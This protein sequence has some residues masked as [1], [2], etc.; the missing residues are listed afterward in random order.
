MNCAETGR[1]LNAYS[2]GEL[3]LPLALGLEEHLESC[4][5]CRRSFAS[6]QAVRT[7]VARGIETRAAPE[8]LRESLQAELAGARRASGWRRPLRSPLAVAAPGLIALLLA[9]W[10]ALAQLLPDSAPPQTR[11]VY[12]IS[13][14]DTASAALRNLG[15][16][17]QAAPEAKIVVVAHNN[18]VD[19]LLRGARDESGRAYDAAVRQF[20][21]RG[22]EFRVCYNT[23]ERRRI[24]AGEVIPEATLVPSGIAEI[25][26]LQSREGYVYMRL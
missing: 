17:L 22:V 9:G 4:A 15:N 26:R 11:V 13:S 7:A 8:A 21:Q 16:H 5:R 18:G 24:A 23:L 3:D 2:D 25:G 14:S 12:H 20:R 6:L 1:L 19:F 10:L